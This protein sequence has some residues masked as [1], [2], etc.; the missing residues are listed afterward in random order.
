[1]SIQKKPRPLLVSWLVCFAFAAALLLLCS[2]T[3]PLYNGHDWT[4]ANT[5][6][7]MARGLLRGTV[8]YRDLF[9]HKG[10]LLYFVYALGVL[11]SPSGFFGVFLLQIVALGTTL[12][13]LYQT[14]LLILEDRSRAAASAAVLPVFL[15]TSG[16]YYLPDNLDYGGGSAEEFCLP[17]FA[18][19]LWLSA[20]CEFRGTW[21]RWPM[22]SMGVLAGCVCLVKFNLVLFWV[23][24]LL[25]VF[26]RFLFRREW[27]P[28]LFSALWG[29][30]GVMAALAPY[31]LYGA[32]TGSLDDFF[33]AYIQFNRTYAVSGSVFDIIYKAVQQAYYNLLHLP[34]LAFALAALLLG[35]LFLR[36]APLL[37]RAC[38]L[39]A[40]GS[41]GFAIFCGRS[42]L[43]TQL[44]L[45]LAVFPGAAA[46]AGAIPGSWAKG[47]RGALISG[48]VC[49][50]LGAAAVVNNQ[51][52][53]CKDFFWSG[54]TT[55][56]QEMAALIR[57][58]PYEAP[59]LL[60]AGMLN[61]G[62]YNELDLIPTIYYF[63]LPNVTYAQCPDILDS[64]LAAIEGEETD[65]VVLQS[66]LPALTPDT[67]PSDPIQAQ[68]CQAALEHYQLVDVVKGT[69]AVDHLYYHLFVRR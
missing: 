38:V 39:L 32:A 16:I 19:A 10:P 56:Q 28:F 11:I 5:Y 27:K 59:T 35:L 21:G 62:Y 4:D 41:L 3:S 57:S 64:Q 25:P 14:A 12:F 53:F 68:L 45:L 33:Y 2:G 49:L 23:G 37:W 24:L 52:V 9:D 36:R 15:L 67:L 20:R 60:E 17:L 42:M 31:L 43:Y 34:I 48:L 65:Y 6:L 44:P 50:A 69:G 51:V 22:F 40:F 58:G 47:T 8:P 13:F 46:L 26:L 55:C 63:Y 30:L 18:A 1:M 66:D 7:T 61:R 29:A 54:K